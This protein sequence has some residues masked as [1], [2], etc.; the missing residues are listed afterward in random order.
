M[1]FHWGDKSL[2]DWKGILQR[3]RTKLLAPWAVKDDDP[4][5]TKREHQEDEN[6]DDH[7][8]AFQHDIGRIIHC[9]AFR[10]LKHKTQ[11]FISYEKDHFRTR[12]THTLEVLQIAT[13]VARTL[14][15][16]EDIVTAIALGHDLGHTPF[17][18]AGEYI[19]N[20]IMSGK[21]NNLFSS[22]A[23]DILNKNRCGFKH[24][25]QSVRVVKELEET[26]ELDKGFKG[27]NLTKE[28][29]EGIL[30][31]T[32]YPQDIFPELDPNKVPCLEGQLIDI[33][34]E[35]AQRA[36]DLDDGVRSGLIKISDVEGLIKKTC[37]PIKEKDYVKGLI[38]A[39]E[40]SLNSERKGEGTKL[41]L[42]ILIN[43][44]INCFAI[45]L[46]KNTMENIRKKI[47]GKNSESVS[48]EIFKDEFDNADK[49]Q[50]KYTV[51]FSDN[52]EN[53]EKQLKE[54]EWQKIYNSHWANCRDKRAEY[55]IARLFEA[56]IENPLILPN[57][58]LGRFGKT[59]NISIEDIRKLKGENLEA[60]LDEIARMDEFIML[61]CNHISGMTDTYVQNKYEE[62]FTPFEIVAQAK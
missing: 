14:G 20:K 44:L 9:K 10:R 7:R 33:C 40:E 1:V 24:N 50:E 11:V 53:L 15:L 13:S 19:L 31:H 47:N 48:Y 39:L 3:E 54:I 29:M 22:K 4:V 45:D 43:A 58:T 27:L 30:K 2:R 23:K 62:L 41:F 25:V 37:E 49:K 32:K 35:I 42:P 16:N 61:V 34:D 12:L 18:H 59:T 38:K 56:Y 36:H 21:Y 55:F 5:A 57:E 46:I 8:T 26:Y 28:V 51:K 60:R 17:G 52:I 6:P